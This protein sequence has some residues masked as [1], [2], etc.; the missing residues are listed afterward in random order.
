MCMCVYV[1]VCVCVCV[2][3]CVCA[4]VCM[5]PNACGL[6]VQLAPSP[7]HFTSHALK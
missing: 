1:C 5:W 6:A 4:C 2:C 3:A 7:V